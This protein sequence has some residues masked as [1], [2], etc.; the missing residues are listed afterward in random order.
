MRLAD[1]LPVFERIAP[2]RY[3][4]SWDNVGLIAGDPE[5]A[6]DH[7]LLTIDCTRS[8]LN[9]AASV[10]A[11]LIFAYHPPLFEGIKNVRAG[12]L[13]YQAIRQNMA[14]YSPH[15]ALDVAEGGTNDLLAD[16]AGLGARRP[17][18][19]IDGKDSAFKLVTFVPESNVENVAKAV[20]EAGGGNIGNYTE[21]SFQQ[22][23][24]GTFRG[25]EGSNPVIGAPGQLEKVNEVR[26][27]TL[28]LHERKDA[29]IKALLA[30]HP[31][32]EPAFDLLRLVPLASHVGIGRVGEYAKPVAI[33]NIIERLKKGLSVSALLVA[34][35]IENSV[36]RIA[37]CAG[38]GRGLLN[39]AL[40][41]KAQLFITGELPHH[42]A[43]RAAA[44]G[45]TVIC[46]LHSNSERATLQRVA[47]K[48]KT[49]APNVRVSVST[50][51]RDPYQVV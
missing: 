3:A 26:F 11:N 13:V 4:E 25:G 35:D 16:V 30:A 43:L 48:L 12:S 24:T 22:V 2:L 42:D 34:G 47:E 37:M 29:V 1:L 44:A 39:D 28:V 20:F 5:S 7:I 50:E 8:V 6:I 27:E 23:G 38:A 46:A 40:A 9:E 31:Y 15:T 10:G 41:Q 32:E 19:R 21:C 36:T 49:M 51:D 14:L 17:L 45:M 18:K 33:T